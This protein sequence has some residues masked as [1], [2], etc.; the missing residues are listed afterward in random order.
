M[1]RK[2]KVA[3][4]CASIVAGV[5]FAA[6]RVAATRRPQPM[7]HVVIVLDRS[8]STGGADSCASAVGLAA[9]ALANPALG[10]GSTLLV[11][12]TGDAS[13][14]YEPAEVARYDVPSTRRV[15]EG[16]HAGER[17]RNAILADLAKRCEALPRT[18]VSPILLAVRRGV[19]HLRAAGC[20]ETA[21]CFLYVKT[22]GRE[23]ADTAVVQ[24]LAGRRRSLEQLPAPL[25]PNTGIAVRLC[26]FAE[27]VGEG[28]AGVRRGKR[29]VRRQ[30]KPRVDYRQ[31][32]W[33]RLM[34]D[35]SP[36]TIEPYC[37]KAQPATDTVAGAR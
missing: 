11:L 36:L 32:V 23:T 3:L 6:V 27:T 1:T 28:D 34:G 21:R 22:D 13:T 5:G 8:G 4:V 33:L 7:S 17:R 31:D 14:A 25:L 12:A 10:R 15:M 9:D 16:R 37:P 2:L 29:R 30:A 19:E 35:A 24:A 18:K 20:A 26:G